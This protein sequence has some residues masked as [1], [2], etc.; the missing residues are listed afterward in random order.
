M[1]LRGKEGLIHD[2]IDLL[3]GQEDQRSFE[4]EVPP[5]VKGGE[6]VLS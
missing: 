6:P 4:V 2:Y 3:M 1:K 5:V